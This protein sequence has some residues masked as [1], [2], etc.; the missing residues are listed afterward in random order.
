VV[1]QDTRLVS[2]EINMLRDEVRA[3]RDALEERRL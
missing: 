1:D 3:L 2:S